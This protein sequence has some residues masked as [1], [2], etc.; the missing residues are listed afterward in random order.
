[1]AAVKQIL[2]YVMGTV[3]YGIFYP[4]GNHGK[5]M[6]Y[7]DNNHNAG[8]DDGRSTTGHVFYLGKS[9]I[10]WCSQK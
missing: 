8:E 9:P 2:R 1:M 7:S 6:G 10:T 3:G 5:L 4:H